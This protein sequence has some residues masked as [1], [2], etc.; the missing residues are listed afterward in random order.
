MSVP[1]SSDATTR[2]EM[3]VDCLD[4]EISKMAS[5][6]Q[7]LMQGIMNEKR[8]ATDIKYLKRKVRDTEQELDMA[9]LEVELRTAKLI[10]M[11]AT[12]DRLHLE[13]IAE[14]EAREGL[15]R[16]LDGIQCMVTAKDSTPETMQLADGTSF[17]ANKL[18]Y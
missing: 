2:S 3:F 9:N 17:E 18:T 1:V 7:C 16:V 8:Q 13:Y 6:R 15:Q 10:E 5:M 12:A 14:R 11:K 4:N